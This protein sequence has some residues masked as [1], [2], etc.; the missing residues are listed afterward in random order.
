VIPGGFCVCAGVPAGADEFSEQTSGC[1]VADAGAAI[2]AAAATAA[3]PSTIHLFTASL[4]VIAGQW[5]GRVSPVL[6]LEVNGAFSPEV[7]CGSCQPHSRLSKAWIALLGGGRS[8]ALRG[9][10]PPP[11]ASAAKIKDTAGLGRGSVHQPHAALPKTCV[12]RSRSDRPEEPVG[13]AA[14]T[15]ALQCHRPDVLER[16]LGPRAVPAFAMRAHPVSGDLCT[17]RFTCHPAAL[18]AHTRPPRGH[19]NTQRPGRYTTRSLYSAVQ[20]ACELLPLERDV[21]RSGRAGAVLAG[22]PPQSPTARAARYRAHPVPA[23]TP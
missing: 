21:S 20:A 11:R 8:T 1:T 22:T 4:P 17:A 7:D 12:G 6:D 18:R 3:T 2:D 13:E 23:T 9:G 14:G 19:R 15:L 16:A 5:T 10:I